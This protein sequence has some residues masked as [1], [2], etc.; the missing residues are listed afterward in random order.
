MLDQLLAN[1]SYANFIL[2][3]AVLIF[4]H[5]LGHY[6]AARW[7]G[8]RVEVFSVGFGPELFG[9]TDQ[10]GTRWK[11]SIIP[12]GGYVKMFGEMLPGLNPDQ[13]P[14]TKAQ[15][16]FAFHTRPLIARSIVVAAGPIANFL[17]AFVAL[18]ISFIWVGKVQLPDF[19]DKGVGYV[20]ENSPADIAG[21][22]VGDKIFAVDNIT[23]NSFN[24]M[25]NKVLA[26]NGNPITFSINRQGQ[27]LQLTATPEAVQTDNASIYRLGIS[28]PAAIVVQTGIVGGAVSAVTETFNI[29]WETLK[30]LGELMIGARSSDE[31]GGPIKIAQLSNDIGQSGFWAL[32]SFTIVLSINLGLLN[33]L[34]IP[35]LDGGYLL[36]CAYEAIAGKPLNI[37]VQNF[38]MRIGIALV[39]TLIIFVTIN[40]ILSFF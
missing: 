29:A 26:S 19:M 16:S 4:V 37:K 7:C 1:I 24:D 2:V 5:E 32:L 36:F 17:Y 9:Y 40:D 20:L 35:V 8:V 12:L 30:A 33:L 22:Q 38:A 27:T 23:I 11:F 15:E 6:L 14:L 34:P 31:L 3:L 10:H 28:A 13:P 18:W 39:A 25:R 21:I